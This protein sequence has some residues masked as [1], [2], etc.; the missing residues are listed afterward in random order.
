VTQ[1]YSGS[2]RYL[3]D[4]P[5]GSQSLFVA[6]TC[7]FGDLPYPV[8]ALVDTAAEWCILPPDWAEELGIDLTPDPDVRP[9][10]TRFG[11]L[12]GRLQRLPIRIRAEDGDSLRVD[13]TLFGSPD[14]HGPPVLG[15]KGCLERVRFGL[16]P[17]ED[18]FY[19]ASL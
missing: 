16:D 1:T 17:A 6:V 7:Y 8:H 10:S 18:R 9:Y 13:A 4:Y 11:K 5:F 15:W 19:F 3:A 14:W 2:A 12:Q